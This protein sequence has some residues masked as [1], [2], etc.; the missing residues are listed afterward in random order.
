MS[1][2]HTYRI[3]IR[4]QVAQ[5]EVYANSPIGMA[6]RS[7]DKTVTEVS[8]ETDQSGL[9]GLVRHL[10]GRGFAILSISDDTG[11]QS[12]NRH[13]SRRQF[14][15]TGRHRRYNRRRDCLR[16]DGFAPDPP[17]VYRAAFR[18]GGKQHV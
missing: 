3:R 8:V 2:L 13:M 4:G 15:K 6:A 1:N 16:S 10:H 7:V 9:I 12:C 11:L 5:T 17:P 18:F 14:L